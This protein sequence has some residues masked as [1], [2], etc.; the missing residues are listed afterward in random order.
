M[1]QKRWQPLQLESLSSF[2]N[3]LVLASLLQKMV[4]DEPVIYG[5]KM[6]SPLDIW[7][8]RILKKL[9]RPD[10]SKRAANRLQEQLLLDTSI[11]QTHLE[12]INV[13]ASKFH[14]DSIDDKGCNITLH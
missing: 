10:E 1:V 13:I 9:L 4:E 7:K 6:E 14:L 12:F 3:I 5:T 11:A 2:P 8:E